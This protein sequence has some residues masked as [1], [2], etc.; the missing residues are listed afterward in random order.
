MARY[1][2]DS[3]HSIAIPI[4]EALIE[5][6]VDE[7]NASVSPVAAASQQNA[8]TSAGSVINTR[9]DDAPV[10]CTVATTFNAMLLILLHWFWLRQLLSL[11]MIHVKMYSLCVYII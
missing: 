5:T 1:L 10:M 11:L 8:T 9:K 2:E 3:E 6:C 4:A 7:T